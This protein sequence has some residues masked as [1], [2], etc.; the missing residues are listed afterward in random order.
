M[1]L[2]KGY[3][4]H[5]KGEEYRRIFTVNKDAEGCYCPNCMAAMTPKEAMENYRDLLRY[6]LKKGSTA[7]F[8]STQYLSAYQSFAH[9]IDINPTV[10]VARFGRVLSLVYLSTL[11]K[12]KINFALSLHKQEA[13]KWYHYQE[14]TDE[15]YHFLHL[16][17][18]AL[19]KYETKM[20]RRITTHNNIY[21]D[22]D[23]VTL[24]L[25]RIKEIKEYREFIKTEA[26]IFIENGKPQFN[27]I[28]AR[29]EKAIKV[30][31]RVLKERYVVA[32]DYTYEFQ[33]YDA[34]GKPMLTIKDGH[35]NIDP[36]R[37]KVELYPKDNKKSAIK[38]ELY[39][40][41]VALYRFV[42]ASIPVAI[43]FLSAAFTIVM[44]S[45]FLPDKVM[46]I[47]NFLVAIGL[48]L[49][50]GLLFILHLAWKNSLKK[51]FYNGINPFI[52]K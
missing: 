22:L 42:E 23:C 10:K 19:D 16:L 37:K 20:R 48:V 44:I 6:H 40:N 30:E 26:D 18:T 15:Y 28:N 3:C 34:S 21:Y 46:K 2:K 39:M 7:L 29:I 50:A 12:S 43:V 14:T 4:W 32:D 33:K 8:E 36:K 51:R 17:L 9:V 13:P 11:R 41:N 24:Y 45:I 27:E 25:E 47:L 49:S 5:C 38:D 1:A 31:D 52:L 35:P